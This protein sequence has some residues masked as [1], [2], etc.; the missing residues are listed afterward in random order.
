MMAVT[1]SR[2]ADMLC[3]NKNICSVA[4]RGL[5]ALLAAG[6]WLAAACPAAL[7]Q[8]AGSPAKPAEPRRF[9]S[10]WRL[11]G[12][13][14]AG[15][16]AAAHR[17]REGDVVNVGELLRAAP[18]GEAV[19]KT[20]DGGLLALRPNAQLLAVRYAA[21]GKPSDHLAL[22]LLSGGLRMITGWI[23]RINRA[24]YQVASP[25][26]TI[27]IRG[28]DHEPFV[29]TDE[30]G[31]SLKQPVGTYDKV[32]QGGT[33]LESGGKGVDIAPGQVGF[34][35]AQGKAR[36]RALMTLALPVLLD[37]VPDFY[38]P[39]RFDAELD[40]LSRG[41]GDAAQQQY[42][43]LRAAAGGGTAAA[44]PDA[45][46]GAEPAARP[47]SAAASAAQGAASA[48]NAGKVCN[49][50]HVARA[51]L[52][53]LDSAISRRQPQ[54]VL[55]LFTPEVLVRVTVRGS[56]GA[57]TTLDL[58]RDEFARS[59]IAALQNLTHYQQRRPSIQGSAPDAANCQRIAVSSVVIEQG[60]QGGQPFRFESTETYLLERRSGQWLAVQAGTTQR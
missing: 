28:T 6:L 8:D 25:T 58:G 19:L 51:W 23:G 43:K 56:G 7:A 9:A 14:S 34:V 40:Q 54:D 22:K 60:Q 16:G 4:R 2:G 21:E 1:I 10:V 48:A 26:A 17:L 32:N 44:T 13:V 41:V 35:R 42:D 31:D 45:G 55:A 30:M 15:E 11:Q 50:T 20:E 37:K 47:A 27:G 33:T 52:R 39:G 24:S 53:Q 18:T 38:V 59:S 49:A 3:H 57:S 5:A 29:L 36:T 12:E 46:P